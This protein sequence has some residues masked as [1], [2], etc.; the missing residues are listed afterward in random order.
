MHAGSNNPSLC[1]LSL[2]LRWEGYYLFI[3]LTCHLHIPDSLN[4]SLEIQLRVCAFV[5]QWK[6]SGSALSARNGRALG[7]ACGRHGSS[8]GL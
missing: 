4:P 8:P 6:S 7:K 2:A 3:Q 5:P 1:N